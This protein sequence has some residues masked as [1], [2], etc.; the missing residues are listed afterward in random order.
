MELFGGL[1]DIAMT[2]DG[3]ILVENNDLKQVQT[4]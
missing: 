2:P 3:D 1:T 4:S